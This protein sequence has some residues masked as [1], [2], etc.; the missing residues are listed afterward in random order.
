MSLV[1]FDAND[2]S[3]NVVKTGVMEI[4]NRA[5]MFGAYSAGFL[6]DIFGIGSFFWPFIFAFLGAAYISARIYLAWWRWMGIFLLFLCLLTLSSAFDLAIG[7]IEGGG[8][9]GNTFYYASQQ[10]L[11]PA[12][13]WLLWIFVT[14]SGLQLAGNFSWIQLLRQMQD[15][16]IWK[17]S[18][19]LI[20]IFSRPDIQNFYKNPLHSLK[21]KIKNAYALARTKFK[22]ASPSIQNLPIPN[23]PPEIQIPS[24]KNPAEDEL[25][26]PA[27][28]EFPVQDDFS[29]SGLSPFQM[30]AN[31]SDSHVTNQLAQNYSLPDWQI[32][33]EIEQ[34]ESTVPD[35]EKIW[36]ASGPRSTGEKFP[37]VPLPKVELLQ[38][39]LPKENIREDLESK[40]HALI[41]CFADFDI[42]GQLVRITPGPVV[43]MFEFR[44]DPGIRISKIANL[45]DELSLAL[46]A[47]AVRIQAPIPGSDAVG[48]EIPNETRE[49]VNFREL[50]ESPEFQKSSSPLTMIL[51]KDI[52]GKPY[53]ADL[54]DMPH[55]LMAGATGAGKSVCLNSILISML[56]KCQPEEMRL[57][58]VDPKRV[59]MA[60]YADLPHLVHPVV[61]DMND[62]KNAL[63]WATHEM[64]RR[65]DAMKLLNARNVV[66]YNQKLAALGP[67]RLEEHADLEPFPYIVIVIDELAD[68]M[69]TAGR[70]VQNS[71]VRLAQLARA[72]GIH[73]ILATQRPSVDIVTGLIKANFINRISFQVTSKHDSRTILDQSGAEYLLGRGDMLFKPKGGK[74]IRLH[75]PFLSD[76]EVQLVANYW[77]SQREPEYEIDFSSWNADPKTGMA[78]DNEDGVDPLYDEAK[79]FVIE[80]G[81][82]SISQLQRRL[83]IGFARSG[84]LI[85]QLERGGIIGPDNGSKPRQV[86]QGN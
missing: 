32:E 39:P 5:G 52:S 21:T 75:G 51:G 66:A 82:A 3:I 28:K 1:T 2:P 4:K 69:M 47:V 15:K 83:K 80:Q 16:I 10:Y 24:S 68:L 23:L 56:Y 19:R 30:P 67:N 73:M 29:I 37:P 17:D 86:L 78:A 33:E 31:E 84:R 35:K 76:E 63:D 62:A 79:A 53:M 70:E 72:A 25:T 50:V 57:L 60:V 27:E 59:E 49:I 26:V 46:K 12:G 43:T 77:K 55:L 11:S 45:S 48:I 7:D 18:L 41:K 34:S 22:K 36:H 38:P 9:L 81:R 58:L 8:I 54:A 85:D 61:T 20:K 71:I 44:P 65:F 74:L 40:G 42:Q 14:L 13:S 64:E 6:N